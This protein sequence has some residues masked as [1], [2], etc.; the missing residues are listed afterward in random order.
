MI[1]LLCAVVLAVEPLPCEYPLW[2]IPNVL[3]TPHTAGYSTVIDRRHVEFL[4]DNMRRFTLDEPLRNQVEK[5][6]WI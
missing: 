4:I 5:A 3:L 1:N 2:V 6:L